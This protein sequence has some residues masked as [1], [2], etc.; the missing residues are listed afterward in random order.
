MCGCEGVCI[1]CWA[2]SFTL[3]VGNFFQVMT[4]HWV[5]YHTK[6]YVYTC[7][8]HVCILLPQV[9]NEQLNERLISTKSDLT[10]QLA[11][12]QT[13]RDIHILCIV[14]VHSSMVCTYIRVCMHVCACVY[15]LMCVCVCVCVRRCP[16][17]VRSWRD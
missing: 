7:C 15:V 17:E 10:A 16:V 12:C 11:Q 5:L 6:L 4:F 13:V 2:L 3:C 1:A 8:H 9:E 14:Y